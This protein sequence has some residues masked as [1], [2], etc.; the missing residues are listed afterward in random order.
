METTGPVTLYRVFKR[1]EPD[2][3]FYL[4]P[5][6]AYGDPPEDAPESTRRAWNAWSFYTSE[7]GA[8]LCG[9]EHT[10]LGGR[11]VRF[12]I[13]EGAGIEWDEPDEEGHTNVRG[14]KE[15][16][17]LYRDADYVAKVHAKSA[18]GRRAT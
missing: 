10:H 8:R 17:K 12:H 15:E 6:E 11:I 7:A 5:Q 13:P 9:M 2:D 16:L 18:T 14:N 3:E 4:T 1:A